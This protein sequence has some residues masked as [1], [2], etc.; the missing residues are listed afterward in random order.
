[1]KK[2]AERRGQN[3]KEKV[4]S[5]ARAVAEGQDAL[6]G[7]RRKK[8]GEK[9][10]LSQP[11]PP[12]PIPP[13][14]HNAPS[15][16]YHQPTYQPSYLLDPIPTE[17]SHDPA[18]PPLPIHPHEPATS[19]DPPWSQHPMRPHPASPGR[20]LLCDHSHHVAPVFTESPGSPEPLQPLQPPQR[21]VNPQLKTK[22]EL[23]IVGL[24]QRFGTKS[25][26][27]EIMTSFVGF[28]STSIRRLEPA[29]SAHDGSAEVVVVP[30]SEKQL[31]NFDLLIDVHTLNP[32]TSN[33]TLPFHIASVKKTVINA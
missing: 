4:E 22:F 11:P 23:K 21:S 14:P 1:M 9:I 5:K 16:T 27:N 26:I 10:T 29:T 31:L 2:I 33:V 18:S 17:G 3:I 6:E 20:E 12:L 8:E 25:F 7:W 13:P 15:A 28:G 24:S 30:Q 19:P 32:R